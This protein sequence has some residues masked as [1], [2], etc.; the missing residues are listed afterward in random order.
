MGGASISRI[1]AAAT[2]FPHRSAQFVLQVT[3]PLHLSAFTRRAQHLKPKACVRIICS[4]QRG[5]VKAIWASS[6]ADA[7]R[8]VCIPRATC[9]GVCIRIARVSCLTSDV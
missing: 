4:P 5:Q 8:Q 2:A 3:T 9:I 7:A 6:S 1:D